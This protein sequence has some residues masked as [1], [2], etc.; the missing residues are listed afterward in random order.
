MTK[1]QE[2]QAL[3]TA[4]FSAKA[5]VLSGP[6]KTPFGYYIYEVKSITPGNQQTLAQVEASIKQQLTAT[7]AADGAEQVRQG[8]QKEV[9]RRRPNAAP[10]TSVADCKELQSA[11]GR[12][13]RRHRRAHGRHLARRRARAARSDAM[14]AQ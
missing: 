13:R 11:Q 14:R 8:I 9:D 12:D 1:G 3:D 6:V 5:N 2:E 10:D 4:I 7:A